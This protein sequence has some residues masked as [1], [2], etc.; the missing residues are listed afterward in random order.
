MHAVFVKVCV[1]VLWG[2]ERPEGL[3]PTPEQRN[4]V[5]NRR[6]ENL[7]RPSLNFRSGI[8]CFDGITAL[9]CR[10]ALAGEGGFQSSLSILKGGGMCVWEKNNIE[11]G[12]ESLQGRAMPRCCMDSKRL[13]DIMSEFSRDVYWSQLGSFECTLMYRSSQRKRGTASVHTAG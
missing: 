13:T 8:M 1:C 7:F 11:G 5:R 2:G 12:G 10:G 3:P 9:H 6:T 4:M